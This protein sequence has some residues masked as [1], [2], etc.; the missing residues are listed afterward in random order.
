LFGDG[1]V[2]QLPGPPGRVP[3]RHAQHGAVPFTG[4][5]GEPRL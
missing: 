4:N 3:G 2:A 5:K 1:R